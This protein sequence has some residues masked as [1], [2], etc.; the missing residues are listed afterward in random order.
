MARRKRIVARIVLPSL[1]AAL[2]VSVGGA[3]KYYGGDSSEKRAYK[4]MMVMK[5]CVYGGPD[6]TVTVRMCGKV[7]DERN[8]KPVAG[9][10]VR[11]FMNQDYL[12]KE[13]VTEDDGAFYFSEEVWTG[14]D[15]KKYRIVLGEWTDEVPLADRTVV[16]GKDEV[17][18]EETFKIKVPKK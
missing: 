18:T 12:L 5:P 17:Y 13:M 6:N 14:S 2:G 11:I 7:L 1:L 15:E 9:I 16:L 3:Q 4:A 10:R 8:G